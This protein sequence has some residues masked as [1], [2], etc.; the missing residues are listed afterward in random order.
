MDNNLR[1]ILGPYNPWW[2]TV[3]GTRG[4]DIPSLMKAETKTDKTIKFKGA[5]TENFLLSLGY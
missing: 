3:K 4:E 1:G 5:Q 2:D